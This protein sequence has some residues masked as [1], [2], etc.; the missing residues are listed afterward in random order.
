MHNRLQTAAEALEPR[1]AEYGRMLAE[2]KPAGWLMSGSGSTL[3]ALARSAEDAERIAAALTLRRKSDF[4][5][6]VTRSL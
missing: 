3:F 1:V 5:L 6:I 4:R 2:A